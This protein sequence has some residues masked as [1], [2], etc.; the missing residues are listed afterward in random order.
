MGI[1]KT[2]R[3]TSVYRYYDSS[4]ILLYV[5]ISRRLLNRMYNHELSSDWFRLASRVTLSHYATQEDAEQAEAI[6]I[7]T[8]S[9]MFNKSEG[10][11][12]AARKAAS[13]ARRKK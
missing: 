12:V 8:E 6:A 9:P 2:Q 3:L 1:N 5:G 13:I 10:R 11:T 4:G 7:K